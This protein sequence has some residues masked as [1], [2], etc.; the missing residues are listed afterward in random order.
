MTRF[1]CPNCKVLL[2]LE[3]LPTVHP[4]TGAGGQYCPSCH[5]P[6]DEQ[7]CRQTFAGFVNSDVLIRQRGA[8]VS[9]A[10]DEYQRAEAAA[11]VVS[12]GDKQRLDDAVAKAETAAADAGAAATAARA[13]V[14]GLGPTP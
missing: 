3:N 10:I 7:A 11:K 12:D 5:A 14:S 4:K 2:V 6:I 9:A 1:Q 13:A 8:Q